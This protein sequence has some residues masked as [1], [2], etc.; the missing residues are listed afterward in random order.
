MKTR[1][2]FISNSSS[3]SFV[4][5]FPLP[6]PTSVEELQRLLFKGTQSFHVYDDVVGAEQAA[7]R[8][9]GDFN[10]QVP[11]TLEDIAEELGQ[12]WL[13]GAPS[14]FKIVT[15]DWNDKALHAQ[16]K[17]EY[18]GQLALFVKKLIW[19]KIRPELNRGTQFY[20]FSYS[21][22]DGAFE[23]ALEHGD[24]FANLPHI[25]ISHH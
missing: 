22:N 12:G 17:T 14:Y 4:V 20:R 2:G 13:D 10:G 6:R 25:Q 16:Q 21:D 11:M 19:E 3:S 18:E 7:A 9:W 8:V 5:G 24:I 1:A 15:A 23:A